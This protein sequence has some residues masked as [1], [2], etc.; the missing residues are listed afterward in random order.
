MKESLTKEKR[1][2]PLQCIAGDGVLVILVSADV[3][4]YATEHHPDFYNHDSDVYM[5]KV[6]NEQQWLESV[7]SRLTEQHEGGSTPLSELFDKVIYTAV[8]Q[9]DEGLE[10]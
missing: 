1:L 3:V 2:F 8:D 10:E 6:D 7:A 9:G 5:V 4:K